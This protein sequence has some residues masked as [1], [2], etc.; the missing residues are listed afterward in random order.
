MIAYVRTSDRTLFI[1]HLIAGGFNLIR[2]A[3][4][5]D[6]WQADHLS[7]HVGQDELRFI[8]APV[9]NPTPEPTR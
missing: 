6:P 9:D 3:P 8:R 2:N 1:R 7:D 4:K 5:S